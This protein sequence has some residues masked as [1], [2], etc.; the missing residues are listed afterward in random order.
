MYGDISVSQCYMIEI[1]RGTAKAEEF[2]RTRGYEV[3]TRNG[4]KFEI[5]RRSMLISV[6]G[7]ISSISRASVKHLAWLFWVGGKNKIRNMTRV[8]L[9]CQQVSS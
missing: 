8:Q 4:D 9:R 2:E 6:H 7:A 5:A 1:S 3:D